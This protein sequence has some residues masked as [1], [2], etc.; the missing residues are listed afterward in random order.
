VFQLARGL[1]LGLS[2]E[3]IHEL[4]RIDP[5]FLRQIHA[6]AMDERGGR[7]RRRARRSRRGAAPL[8]SA[9]ASDRQIAALHRRPRD[10]GP[11]ARKAL[12]VV[13][14]YKRVDTCAAEFEAHTPYL[15]S[16]YEDECE[17]A[18]TD[19]QAR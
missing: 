8:P 17:A 2:V 6:M 3:R 7:R 10:R 4:T 19:A 15:Y 14:V 12:G 11:R 18:P 13:P 16:T 5:W 1:Q 9:A